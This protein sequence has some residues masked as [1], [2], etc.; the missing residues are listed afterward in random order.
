MTKNNTRESRSLKESKTPQPFII[1]EK[2]RI[3]EVTRKRIESENYFM[4][5]LLALTKLRYS[6]ARG[7]L[8]SDIDTKEKTISVTKAWD[9]L[10]H[11]ISLTK[12]EDD[13]KIIRIS[14]TA[15]EAINEYK[16]LHCQENR[17]YRLFSTVSAL[18]ISKTLEQI[19]DRNTAAYMPRFA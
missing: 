13:I 16:E 5:H 3:L 7:L 8:W 14:E 2:Q 11:E 10:S 19:I 15:I 18:S 1:A 12:T 9:S 6:E 17:Q 4:I